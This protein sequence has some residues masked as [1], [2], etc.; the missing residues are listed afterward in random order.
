MLARMNQRR[1]RTGFGIAANEIGSFVKIATEAGEREIFERV[2]SLMLAGCDV[3]N[4]KRDNGLVIPMKVT[5]FA[6][7]AGTLD[8]KPAQ[9][10]VHQD[11]PCRASQRCALA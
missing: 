3:L 5:V 7:V 8:Y 1:Y 2:I 10:D 6:P 4:L 11:A 9:R